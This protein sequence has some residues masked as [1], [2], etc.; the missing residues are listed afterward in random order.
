MGGEKWEN[1]HCDCCRPSRHIKSWWSEPNVS[2]QLVN[3]TPW[4]AAGRRLEHKKGKTK[5][6]TPKE[7]DVHPQHLGDLAI[8]NK[9]G[10]GRHR[11]LKQ[12]A[13]LPIQKRGQ[14]FHNLGNRF[15]GGGEVSRAEIMSKKSGDF[16]FAGRKFH[17]S[18]MPMAAETPKKTFWD[19]PRGSCTGTSSHRIFSFPT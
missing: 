1:P 6:D 8:K 3:P 16:L 15:L 4:L 2:W 17:F 18:W 14:T 9:K 12:F 13:H 11:I 19:C 10:H 7:T 5:A